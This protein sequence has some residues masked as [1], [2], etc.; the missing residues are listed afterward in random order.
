MMKPPLI[1]ED[2]SGFCRRAGARFIWCVL[3]APFFL[4]GVFALYYGSWPH[5]LCVTLALL[6]G[7]AN[8]VVVFFAPWRRVVLGCVALFLLPLAAFHLM[9]PSNDRPWQPDV[10]QTPYSEI[11]GDQVTVYNVRNCVYQS[12][13]N[14]TVAFETRHYD[15]S[16]V[17]TADIFL[18]DWGLRKVAHTMLSFGFD[19]GQYLCFSIE[20]RKEVG[21]SYSAFKGLFRQ[22]EVIF[23]AGDERDLV[24]LRTN[25]REG[26]TAR[27]Y[28]LVKAPPEAV[29][30]TF[31]DYL[32]QINRLKEKP[33]WYNAMTGNCMVGFFQIARHHA[34]K[35]RGRWHWSVILNGYAD[36]RA[37]ENGALDTS[38]PLEMLRERSIINSRA[39]AAGNAPEFSALIR[40]GIPG[41]PPKKGEQ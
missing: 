38:L 14:F 22:Y 5:A 41:I 11:K 12:E 6:Y 23:I 33:K 37:Y 27:L 4:W 7:V 19:D 18:V 2:R 17:R 24:G 40:Q 35:G 3:S 36:Q 13:T 28:R 10:A 16:K 21:E 32:E 9:R 39:R 20:T 26:E 25:F 31:L 1:A 34:V 30:A 15:L 29:R 8:L